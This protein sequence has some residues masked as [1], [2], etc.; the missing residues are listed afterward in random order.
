MRDVFDME[1]TKE[2]IEYIKS[3][4]EVD[5]YL[6]LLWALGELKELRDKLQSYEDEEISINL[7]GT[8]EVN[9]ETGEVIFGEEDEEFDEEEYGFIPIEEYF[10]RLDRSLE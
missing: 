5:V 2:R 9:E 6:Q 1:T 10:N 3:L 4:S 8:Y 7:E